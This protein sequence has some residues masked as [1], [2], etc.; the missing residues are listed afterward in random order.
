MADQPFQR[1]C[2]SG[3]R[4]R[5]AIDCL[6]AGVRSLIADHPGAPRSL[7]PWAL[8]GRLAVAALCFAGGLLVA[9]D[10]ARRIAALLVEAGVAWLVLPALVVL[11]VFFAPLSPLYL[12]WLRDRLAARCRT[13]CKREDA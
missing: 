9:E 7:R 6:L 4:S 2:R 5:R 10:F 13:Q 12:S 1:S 11:L 3:T 8:V